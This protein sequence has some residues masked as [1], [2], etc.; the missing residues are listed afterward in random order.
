MTMPV[1]ALQRQIY[2]THRLRFLVNVRP[3]H[4]TRCTVKSC[5]YARP[6]SA[7]NP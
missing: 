6:Q 7:I 5:N 1:V 2:N 3:K 4:V